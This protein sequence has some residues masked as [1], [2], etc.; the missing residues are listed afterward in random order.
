MNRGQR[1]FLGGGKGCGNGLA[2][3]IFLHRA[4]NILDCAP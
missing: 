4:P 3:Q 2:M 1:P